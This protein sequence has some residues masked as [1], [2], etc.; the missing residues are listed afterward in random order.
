MNHL[1][2]LTDEMLSFLQYLLQKRPL[3]A[4]IENGR[5]WN[6]QNVGKK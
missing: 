3:R 1:F 6:S 2:F 5:S 4:V